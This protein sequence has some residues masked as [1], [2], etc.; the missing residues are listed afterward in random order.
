MN[1]KIQER[2]EEL[3]KLLDAEIKYYTHCDSNTE[4]KKIEIIY[5]KQKKSLT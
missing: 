3:I 1:H 2:L 5:D 4:Y